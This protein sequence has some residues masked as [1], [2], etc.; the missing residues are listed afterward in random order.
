[1]QWRRSKLK[2]CV[3]VCG[4]GWGGGGSPIRNLLKAKN[5]KPNQLDEESDTALLNNYSRNTCNVRVHAFLSLQ[6]TADQLR[7]IG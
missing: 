1:M 3:R 5:K 7:L 2:V 4:L 6:S